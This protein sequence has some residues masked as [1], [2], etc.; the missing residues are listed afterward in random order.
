MSIGRGSP[1]KTPVPKKETE[2][3]NNA[4]GPVK[5]YTLTP[6]ELAKIGEKPAPLFKKWEP[7]L[8]RDEYLQNRI[9]GKSRDDIKLR[10][11]NNE[12]DKLVKQLR[13]WKLTSPEK[14]SDEM[15]AK[16]LS[17]FTR[18]MYLERRASGETRT[19]IMGSLKVYTTPFYSLLEEWGLKDKTVEAKVLAGFK[20][21]EPKGTPADREPEERRCE[22]PVP[23]GD[24]ILSRVEQRAV[25]KEKELNDVT[26]LA[27]TW[28]DEANRLRED[29]ENLEIQL[30]EMVAKRKQEN[31]QADRM[32]LEL[33]QN[34]DTEINVII[35]KWSKIVAERD[36]VND[37]LNDRI[38]EVNGENNRL[39]EALEGAAVV[40]NHANARIVELE[41]EKKIWKM[42]FEGSVDIGEAEYQRSE[43]FERE[44][45]RLKSEIA[46]ANDVVDSLR[47][48][49]RK[50]EYERER[51]EGFMF[52][53]VPILQGE[54][55]IGQ[56]V[57][58]VRMV[59]LFASEIESA[60]MD[61]GRA[62]MELF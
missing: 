4:N 50:L 54:H 5:S 13:E 56:R 1:E 24:R 47:S 45:T 8:T 55:P 23:T 57:D 32:L 29:N 58:T 62:A 35:D 15:V 27:E 39:K 20:A 10:W 37:G 22:Q 51:N 19:Q 33:K 6:E 61:R 9:D 17:G 34:K 44:N 38:D 28:Q 18:D 43:E 60:S 46:I 26:E 16:Q 21:Q 14:E 7:T 48:R 11:F 36:L 53:R 2:S 52:I 42:K 25:E 3:R 30:E 59:E 49:V 12:H 41:E 40:A 31:E